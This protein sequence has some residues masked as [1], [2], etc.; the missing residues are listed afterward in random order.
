MFALSP[1]WPS[2]HLYIL[3]PDAFQGQLCTRVPCLMAIPTSVLPWQR[4]PQ[5]LLEDGC[6][7]DSPRWAPLVLGE[8]PPS[9]KNAGGSI[10]R[11]LPSQTCKQKNVFPLLTPGHWSWP[12][13]EQIGQDHKG[14]F[15]Q[16]LWFFV[17]VVPI[18]GICLG[19]NITHRALI[20]AYFI[21]LKCLIS[22][23]CTFP[24]GTNPKPHGI[25]HHTMADVS[26]S[27]RVIII[28][29]KKWQGKAHWKGL[30]KR[31]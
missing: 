13:S 9:W 30:R 19:P 17:V 2:G 20:R 1:I 16:E 27:V 12:V 28:N 10:P 24:R 23:I 15:L 7:A 21:S 25:S 31:V 4:G 6:R 18:F 22:I 8:T 3:F 5:V 29:L 14:T 11:S 26:P